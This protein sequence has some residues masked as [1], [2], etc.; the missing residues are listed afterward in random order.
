MRSAKCRGL[1]RGHARGISAQS[2]DLCGAER[3]QI[4][5]GQIGNRNRAERTQVSAQRDQLIGAQTRGIGANRGDLT[6]GELGNQVRGDTGQARRR[7]GTDLCAAQGERIGAEGGDIAAVEGIDRA[8]Q[9]GQLAGRQR[10]EVVAR[11]RLQVSRAEPGQSRR[12]ERRYHS[13]AQG[14]HLGG[15]QRCDLR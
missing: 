8:P 14:V 12:C 4:R 3:V 10:H 6:G 7:N 2:G 1:S 11:H 13:G 5:A 9:G 15:A